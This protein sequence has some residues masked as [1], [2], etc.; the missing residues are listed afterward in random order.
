MFS[1]VIASRNFKATIANHTKMI[2][3]PFV[4]AY[5]KG[6]GAS[7]AREPEKPELFICLDLN[8]TLQKKKES[9]VPEMQNFLN[10]FR[11]TFFRNPFL[12]INTGRPFSYR[13]EIGSLLK[14]LVVH[15][16]CFLNGTM[17]FKNAERQSAEKYYK[18]AS[19]QIPGWAEKITENTNWSF[20]TIRKA[21]EQGQKK[22]QRRH[23]H[24]KITGK[25]KKDNPNA[26]SVDDHDPK[27][28]FEA[29]VSKEE[30]RKLANELKD[31]VLVEAT[32]A[33]I[34]VKPE[35]EI[36][37]AKSNP[38]DPNLKSAKITFLPR[39]VNKLSALINVVS[40]EIK[41][42]RSFF[43]IVIA[44]NGKNDAPMLIPASILNIPTKR[45]VIGDDYELKKILDKHAKAQEE[46]VYLSEMKSL[47]GALA[48][49]FLPSKTTTPSR[50][51]SGTRNKAPTTTTSRSSSSTK[52]KA[53]PRPKAHKSEQRSRSL[54]RY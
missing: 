21:M 48:R 2:H 53:E 12:M 3:R 4:G 26:S 10:E 25:I 32:K 47:P 20:S 19:Q 30:M 7:Q 36:A 35:V 34:L 31:D 6:K 33:E 41:N 50:S 1:P 39:G 27:M 45:Y 15:T 9:I 37:K 22:F 11:N 16:T 28:Y 24:L 43:S 49:D 5:F 51:S 8:G 29:K 40:R 38:N 46:I 44:G 23:P 42:G 14:E 54:P 52:N 13:E 18:G 17:G